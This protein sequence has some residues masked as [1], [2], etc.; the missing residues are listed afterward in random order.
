MWL[1]AGRRTTLLSDD[2]GW[3]TRDPFSGAREVSGSPQQTQG[4]LDGTRLPL[5][6]RF[7][8]GVR[9]TMSLWRTSAEVT[10]FGGINNVFGHKNTTGYVQ[11]AGTN[12]RRDLRMLPPSVVLG[13]DWRF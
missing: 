13:L 6:L 8:V 12:A 5:Y 9:H 11:P 1:A 10:G 4:P 7:D 2:I 3:D